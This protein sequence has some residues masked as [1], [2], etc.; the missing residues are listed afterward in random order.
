M[1]QHK[2]LIQ[3]VWKEVLHREEKLQL[4][5]QLTRNEASWKMQLQQEFEQHVEQGNKPLPEHRSAQ[6]LQQ[7]HE[8]I[9]LMDEVPVL[10]DKKP[11]FLKAKVLKLA[12]AT[13]A[14]A[15]ILIL[16]FTW[17]AAQQRPDAQLSMALYKPV[18]E[19]KRLI[20]QN[21]KEQEIILEDG[22]KLKLAAGASVVYIDGFRSAD[23]SIK[24]NGQAWFDVAKDSKRP[25]SVTAEGITTTALGTR[26][27]MQ[28][29]TG[30]KVSV[31]LF[32]G[33][34]MV[35][36]GPAMKPVYLHPGEQCIID[37]QL[38]S[39]IAQVSPVSTDKP[40][41]TPERTNS[42]KRIKALEFV[43]AP[44]ADVLTQLGN[45]YHVH[46]I[47]Q[48]EEI[49]N[50]QVTA[51]FLPSDSLPVVLNLLRAANNLSF[52]QQKDTILV[53]KPK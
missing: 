1:E 18:N 11:N 7:L 53:S 35:Q 34:V 14:A 27:M 20:N 15:A 4:L 16:F 12:M 31:Q 2:A 3:K 24:L 45:R 43:Q 44:L 46:F 5:E 38:K 51:V 48:A 8:K 42:L 47:F 28:S 52:N 6:I 49:S 39:A 41:T 37:P 50:D 13:A 17:E 10:I 9:R 29:G 23:R 19:Y 32:E 36:A 33:R 30:K 40:A 21:D 26:F 22:S 25:F